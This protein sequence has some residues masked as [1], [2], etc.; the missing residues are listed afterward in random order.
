MKTDLQIAQETNAENILSI[1]SKLSIPED[2][3]ILYGK[4]KSKVNLNYL[5]GLKERDSKLILVTGINPTKAGEGKSTVTI[6][7]ADGLRAH[8][9]NAMVCLREPSMG[10]VFGLKGGA[11]GGG[12]SQVLPMESINL[13]FTGDMHAITSANNLIAAMLDNSIYQGNP[14]HIDPNQVV[15]KRC[16]DMNDRSLRDITI[17]QK[18]KTNGIEREDHFVITVASEIMAVLCLATS[19]FDLQERIGKI[20]VA[21]SVDGS[22]ITVK[23]IEADGAA[24]LLLKEALM[25]NL[26]QTLEGTPAFIHGGPFANIAHGCNSIIATKSA[27]KMA[28]YVITEAGFGADLGAEKFLD[29]KCRM[30]NLT[31]SAVVIVA[32]IR[33]LKL[34]GGAD[35]SNLGEENVEALRKGVVNLERHVENL[36]SF[37]LPVVIANNRFVSD[38]EAELDFLRNWCQEKGYS[39]A[40]SEGWAKGSNGMGEVVERVLQATSEEN[41]F[42]QLYPLD[43]SVEEKIEA[44]AKNIYGASSVQYSEVALESL[45]QIQK[46]GW[47]KLAICMA[48]TPMS[49]SDDSSLMGAPT[50]F[51]LHVQD[52]RASLGAGFLVVYTGSIMTMPGL[53]KVP[54]ANHIGVDETG[55]SFGLF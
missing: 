7:L 26:V 39:M 50:D 28:D 17:A 52:I 8:G 4:D 36:K 55:K 5:N 51:D 34:H 32:T 12:Y 21:Y 49:F 43:D 35:S 18:K 10:P 46:N 25:P 45:Q 44:I 14:L 47:D 29:I 41:Q 2:E 38:S 40:L 20:L 53:P 11:T 13:H 6:G 37:G 16:L 42:H 31:P 1:A 48:K 30:G 15:W 22:P 3:M 19:L 33:A 23:D 27:L 9:K 54:A 24:T